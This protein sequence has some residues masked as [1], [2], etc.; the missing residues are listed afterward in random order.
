M[1]DA[2]TRTWDG[3]TIPAPGTFALD[4][5]HTTIGFSARHLMVSKVR[6]R[7]GE[8]AGKL[9]VAEDPLQS[10]AEID[11]S[12][13]SF[14]TGIAARDADI[15]GENFLN[16][17]KYPEIK[18]RSTGITGHDGPVF[19]LTGDLTIMDITRPVELQV[20]I[21]GVIDQPAAMGGKQVIGF[22]ITGEIDREDWGITANMALETGGFVVGKKI[23][24]EIEGEAD[25]EG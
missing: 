2:N 24:I 16:V 3:L 1:S 23:K 22:S 20:E 11:I 10:T 13:M 25:R 21:E 7:F 17:Q 12:T 19:T 15:K 14:D 6:G 9:V 5:Y 8:F 18:F 4:P